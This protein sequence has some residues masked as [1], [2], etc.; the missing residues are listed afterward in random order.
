LEEKRVGREEPVS[1]PMFL[2]LFG[3][4]DLDYHGPLTDRRCSK[5]GGEKFGLI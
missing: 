4:W 2:V 3:V 1:E 5:L